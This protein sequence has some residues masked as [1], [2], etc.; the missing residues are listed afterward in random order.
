MIRWFI[1]SCEGWIRWSSGT[2]DRI[3]WKMMEG[4][5]VM[6]SWMTCEAMRKGDVVLDDDWM[7]SWWGFGIYS[8]HLLS[9]LINNLF[10]QIPPVCFSFNF[11][12]LTLHLLSGSSPLRFLTP[13]QTHRT[14]KGSTLGSKP[15]TRIINILWKNSGVESGDVWR[16]RGRL[17]KVTWRWC[18]IG[19]EFWGSEWK[20]P[21]F[22]HQK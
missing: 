5:H 7:E 1:G 15:N 9:L 13:S 21:H 14:W 4:G 12:P 16:W 10:P 6:V 17:G 19:R 3:S 11:S 8:S 18:V 22:S 20:T 2:H